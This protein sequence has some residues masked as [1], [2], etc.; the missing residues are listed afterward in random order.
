IVSNGLMRGLTALNCGLG[1]PEARN[2][3]NQFEKENADVETIKYK[4]ELSLVI[5]NNLVGRLAWFVPLLVVILGLQG[6]INGSLAISSVFAAYILAGELGMPLQS[7]GH[8]LGMIRSMKRLESKI[9]NMREKYVEEA[10]D[11]QIS[12]HARETHV[13][14]LHINFQ[15][16]GL[17]IHEKTILSGVNLSLEPGKKYLVIGRN[18]SG[19]STLFK[20]LKHTYPNYDGKIMLNGVELRTPE[21]SNMSELVS[22]S[23]E[24]VSLLSDTVRNNILLFRNIPEEQLQFAMEKADLHVPLE[25]A[26]GDY[27]KYLSSGERRKL[28]IARA[29]V[30]YPKVL[31]FD[32]VVSTLDIE[33]AYEI[34]K[35]ILSLDSTVVM[36]SNAFSG[37]LLS[38]Y[39]IIVLMDDGCVLATGTHEFLLDNSKEYREIYEIRCG[40]TEGVQ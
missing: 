12:L 21:G 17:S 23:N 5:V 29:I 15:G 1:G 35:L 36:I 10:E 24:T 31:V 19:K 32:E 40:K 34:E 30:A 14:T 16:V 22:Y 20:L 18:G 8:R 37:Q 13:E 27:G 39:D 28:E 3:Q 26:V 6:V 33:T 4:A 9:S 11:K 38:Q 7:I 25:R 2:N